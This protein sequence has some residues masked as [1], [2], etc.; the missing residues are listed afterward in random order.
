[1]KTYIALFEQVHGENKENGY[2]VVF[3]DFPGLITAGNSYEETYRMAHE[4]LASHIKLLEK[5]NIPIPE[6]RTIEQIEDVWEDLKEWKADNDYIIV[7]IES[8]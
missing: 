7:P 1:M 6:P 4:G 2:S 3:P 5:S 8:F